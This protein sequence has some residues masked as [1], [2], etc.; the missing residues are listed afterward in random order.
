MAS[1][2]VFRRDAP[3]TLLTATTTFGLLLGWATYGLHGM[4]PV[5]DRAT[6]STSTWI[7]WTAAAGAL[8]RSRQLAIW[9]GAL[10]MLAT[11]GGYYTAS[12]LGGTFGS[13]GLGTAAVWSMAGLAGGPLLGWAGWTVR[14]GQ[15]EL[16][17]VAGAV[18]TMVVL[19]EGLWFGL[20]LRYRED[21]AAFL[22]AG[23]L[24]TV[25]LT[26]YLA[27]TGAHRYWLCPVLAPVGGLVF[28]LAEK[29]ILNGLLG[30][31]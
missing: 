9:G 30:S 5:L 16:R 4:A 6:N 19:G 22:S 11:C 23:A 27:R 17:A 21:A 14:R 1:T 13:G 10:M 26:V 20:S 24:L 12:T 28:Y 29:G 7:I 2:T 3:V 18:I 31:A 15:G 8:I 25:L